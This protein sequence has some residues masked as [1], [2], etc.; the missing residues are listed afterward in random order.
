MTHFRFGWVWTVTLQAFVPVFFYFSVLLKRCSVS[1]E[2]VFPCRRYDD[3]YLWLWIQQ[4]S[5]VHVLMNWFFG[6]VSL[7][8]IFRGYVPFL[9]IYL[10]VYIYCDFEQIQTQ[11]QI[12]HSLLKSAT[13]KQLQL[14]ALIFPQLLLT[15]GTALK[16]QKICSDM[17]LLLY[18]QEKWRQDWTIFHLHE[19]TGNR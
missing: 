1:S 19:F 10:F 7:I 15:K 18:V 3:M 16:F 9:F 2:V 8:R 6:L 5:S 13:L 4:E 14:V 17:W 12:Q 11:L